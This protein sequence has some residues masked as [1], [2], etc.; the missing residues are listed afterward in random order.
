M[1]NFKQAKIPM[2]FSHIILENIFLSQIK[3]S[4]INISFSGFFW[5]LLARRLYHRS[6]LQVFCPPDQ[7]GRRCTRTAQ[8]LPGLLA[9]QWFGL[10]I[11]QRLYLKQSPGS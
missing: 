1:G 10:G 5:L 6:Q 3:D 2:P 11:S 8:S 7:K 9:E 4:C